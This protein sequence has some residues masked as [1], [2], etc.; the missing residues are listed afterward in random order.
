MGRGVLRTAAATHELSCWL[1]S[2]DLTR[3]TCAE[4]VCQHTQPPHTLPH[5]KQQVGF[6][7]SNHLVCSAHKPLPRKGQTSIYSQLQVINKNEGKALCAVCFQGWTQIQGNCWDILAPNHSAQPWATQPAPPHFPSGLQK[8]WTLWGGRKEDSTGDTPVSL[9]L[10]VLV[11]SLAGHQ[12]YMYFI[13]MAFILLLL[14]TPEGT[15]DA[16]YLEKI[17]LKNNSMHIPWKNIGM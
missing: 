15:Q 3:S 16:I 1:T 2:L 9:L 4:T 17:H 11:F 5:L 14:A 12:Q 10:S 8:P 7:T 13:F 6:I